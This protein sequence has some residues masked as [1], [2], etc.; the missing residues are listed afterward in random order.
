MFELEGRDAVFLPVVEGEPALCF[1]VGKIG[2]GGGVGGVEDGGG[3]GPLERI[4]SIVSLEVG[5]E[6]RKIFEHEKQRNG[7]ITKA[8]RMATRAM[9][10]SGEWVR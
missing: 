3:I 7:I 1:E 9:G 6:K 8:S 5:R 4:V 2:I 10:M